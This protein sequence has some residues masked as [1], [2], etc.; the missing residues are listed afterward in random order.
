MKNILITGYSRG[1]GYNIARYMSGDDVHLI[2]I[3]REFRQCEFT[4]EKY[5][6]DLSVSSNVE[7]IIDLVHEKYVSID[8][9]INNAGIY[10]DNPRFKEYTIF[11]LDYEKLSKTI[12]VNYYAPF[13]LTQKILTK[14]IE[15]GYG[16][17]INV[18][19]GMGRMSE[20]DKYSYAYRLSKL[21]LNSLV[22]TY[23][24]ALNELD[25]DVSIMSVCPGWIK[26]DMGTDDAPDSPDKSAKYIASLY[27]KSKSETNGMFLRNGEILSWMKK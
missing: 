10:I 19:S 2:G 27:K 14:Q 22:V 9:L 1:L 4:I 20:F 3:S 26:T 8:V 13:I 7:K 21:M 25:V 12:S 17:I 16:R 15:Q 24:K 23:G 18:S 6:V 11:D 5:E